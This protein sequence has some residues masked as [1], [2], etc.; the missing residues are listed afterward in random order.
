MQIDHL[1]GLPCNIGKI[2]ASANTCACNE[3]CDTV[4]PLS[5]HYPH[6]FKIEDGCRN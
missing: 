6:F 4:S 1:C 3:L 2:S 5:L